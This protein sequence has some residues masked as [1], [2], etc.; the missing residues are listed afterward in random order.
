MEERP[1]M[2]EPARERKKGFK[3]TETTPRGVSFSLSASSTECKGGG[4][5]VWSR[6]GR[7]RFLVDHPHCHGGPLLSYDAG[8]HGMHDGMVFKGEK[9]QHGTRRES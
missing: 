6:D 4:T 2:S 1:L 8:M 5:D 3:N 9:R 7:I